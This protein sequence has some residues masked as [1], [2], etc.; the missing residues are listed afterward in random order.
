MT[1][2]YKTITMKLSMKYFVMFV[3][4]FVTHSEIIYIYQGS[5]DASH[6]YLDLK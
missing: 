6:T 2:T 3:F 1:I 4:F 5:E